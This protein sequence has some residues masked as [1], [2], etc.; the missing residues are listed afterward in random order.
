M[1]QRELW[2]RFQVLRVWASGTHRAPHKPLLAL[3][4]IGRCLHGGNRMVPFTSVDAELASLLKRF[5]PHRKAMHTEF[6][7][8]RMRNDNLWEIDRPHLVTTTPS[9][10]AHRTSLV[11]SDIHGGLP[12]AV[13]D[14]FHNDPDLAL[15]VAESL[16]EAHFPDT[17]QEQVLRATGV[18]GA[19]SERTEGIA[20]RSNVL[21]VGDT[22]D[23]ATF[24]RRKRNS[25]F[26]GAVLEAYGHQ[27]A[28][29]RFA[30]R[31]E[32]QPL[33]LDAAHIRWHEAAGPAQVRNGMAL[34]TLH[35]RLFDEGAFTVLEKRTKF[36]VL[37]TDMADGLGFNESLKRFQG[38]FLHIP[39][40]LSDQPEP[41]FLKWHRREVFRSSV[42]IR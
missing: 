29:C 1:N 11:D 27:C 13:Y 5:G 28:V 42:S 2:R 41:M 8:W 32:G 22:D 15:L 34:C 3:W 4:A 26:R 35:H 33:A 6:P 17:L 25:A 10:D 37:I 24:R 36:E 30:V 12:A 14:A 39:N 7:F 9:G 23:F 38:T 40:R 20:P 31:M 21:Q 16:V 19:L 18:Y